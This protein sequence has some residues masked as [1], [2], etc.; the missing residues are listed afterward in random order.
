M[1]RFCELAFWLVEIRFLFCP[2]RIFLKYNFFYFIFIHLLNLF[3]RYS[4]GSSLSSGLPRRTVV[5]IFDHTVKLIMESFSDD[6]SLQSKPLVLATSSKQG[7][8]RLNLK[9]Y[10]QTIM[11]HQV[12]NF[13][14]VRL[15][16]V[17]K[18]VI[19]TNAIF[20]CSKLKV[21]K[22]LKELRM[23]GIKYLDVNPLFK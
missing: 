19:I 13:N 7:V 18:N 16:T 3:H 11:G 21:G 23:S 22:K 15:E 20:F 5:F 9:V 14:T 4:N 1:T 8:T 12:Y 2:R 6:V 10:L 17:P